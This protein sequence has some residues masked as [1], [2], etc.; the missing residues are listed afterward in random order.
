MSYFPKRRLG[1]VEEIHNDGSVTFLGMTRG[2][3]MR[4]HTIIAPVPPSSHV[5]YFSSSMMKWE[6]CLICPTER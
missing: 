3:L 5:G 2:V 1:G 6:R 4:I